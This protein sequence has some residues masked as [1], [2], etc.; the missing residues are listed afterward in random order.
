MG[1][2]LHH[3]TD[4]GSV[5]LWV[6]GFTSGLDSLYMSLPHHVQRFSNLPSVLI[7]SSGGLHATI[8]ITLKELVPLTV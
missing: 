2:R 4:D 8:F 6:W 3:R 7:N 1:F 5:G